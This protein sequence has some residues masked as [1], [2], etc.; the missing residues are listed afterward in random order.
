M[1]KDCNLGSRT[2]GKSKPNVYTETSC[3]HDMPANEWCQKRRE[4]AMTGKTRRNFLQMSGAFALAYAAAG[5]GVR[6]SLAA[7][8]KELNIYCWEGYNSDDVLEGRSARRARS[9][10]AGCARRAGRRPARSPR[11]RPRPRARPPSRPIAAA[12]SR[13]ISRIRPFG[14][15]EVGLHEQPV[16][17]EGREERGFEVVDHR[18]WWDRSV[19]VSR[20][21]GA[22]CGPS[23]GS[24]RRAG[25][26]RCPRPGCEIHWP[27]P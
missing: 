26:A 19:A 1:S 6:P 5:Q 21:R 9:R 10:R 2:L 22:R 7:R 27:G 13:S 25:S 16:A 3:M 11:W 8:E 15:C 4:V 12:S 23:R 17:G 18:Q 20:V 14:A 24:P